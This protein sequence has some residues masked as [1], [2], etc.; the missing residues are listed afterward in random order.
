M[1]LEG[2]LD[3]FSL[4]DIFQLLSFTKKTGGLHLRRAA[5]ES[6]NGADAVHG[7]VHF[8]GGAVTGGS[9]DL[10]RLALVRRLVGAG[11]VDDAGLTDALEAVK[12]DPSLSPIRALLQAGALEEE[13]LHDVAREQA[14]DTVYDLLRWPEGDFAFEVDEPD[15][16]SVGLSLPVDEVV[17]EARARL[18]SWTQLAASV[19]SPDTVLALPMNPSGEPALSREEWALLAL[20]D[21]RR[22]VGDLVT[23][24]GRGQFGVVNALA[25]LLNRGL[26]VV[27]GTDD[28]VDALLRRQ[29]LL[30]ALEGDVTTAPPRRRAADRQPPAATPEAPSAPAA[31]A[32]SRHVSDHDF[33]A[34]ALAAA[35]GGAPAPR[36]SA[37]PARAEEAV[38][39][40]R[41]EPFTPRRR[42]EHPD[43]V[44]A[45]IPSSIGPVIGATAVAHDPVTSP[46]GLIERDPSV[47]KSLLLRLIAG[48]RGL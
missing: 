10:S 5:A 20:V 12:A 1:R 31:P 27:R 17:T 24:T 4:P 26:L 48:V 36:Q 25:D 46:S 39:P 11:Y 41:P 13:D 32:P 45:G 2:S 6:S 29:E 43:E 16:D 35:S 47:N 23:L 22:T 28:G 37:A 15:P 42:P 40:A 38:I 18:E 34:A 9:P 7:V 19:P 8:A 14:V 44:S 21:G 30:A 33:A 3:A